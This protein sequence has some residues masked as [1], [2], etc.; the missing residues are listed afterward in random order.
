MLAHSMCK[1][2]K[3]DQRQN[4]RTK[5]KLLEE[6]IGEKIHDTGFGSNLKT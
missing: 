1:V 5:S 3:R 4:V 6:N 2:L